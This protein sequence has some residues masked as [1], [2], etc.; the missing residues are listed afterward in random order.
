[1]SAPAANLDTERRRILSV[2]A[3]SPALSIATEIDGMIHA[4]SRTQRRY[5]FLRAVAAELDRL[6]DVRNT[7]LEPRHRDRIRNDAVL[8]LVRDSF[9][10]LVI[11]LAS[12][13]EGLTESRGLLRRLSQHPSLLR[14]LRPE[15]VVA[16]PSVIIGDGDRQEGERIMFA[17]QREL[18]VRADSETF[19]RLFPGA[20]DAVT[21]DDVNALRN[22]FLAATLPVDRDRN[23]VRAHRFEYRPSD[24]RRHFLP[25]EQLGAQIEVFEDLLVNL[26]LVVAQKSYDTTASFQADDVRT[27]EDLSDLMVFGS[28]NDAVNRLVHLERTP[29]GKAPSYYARREQYLA[30][31]LAQPARFRIEAA[32]GLR[33][34]VAG[35]VR[36]LFKHR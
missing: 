9:D 29:D 14:R 23:H 21:A 15:E 25:L 32:P 8:Q 5:P 35:W 36:A 1:M 6:Q 16:T 10:L 2:L 18:V 27:A 20:G 26:A 12:L 11:D 22:R 17:L 33:Q 28:I 4:L 34:R 19:Q 13:R 24:P 31:T 30:G 7:E 3:R